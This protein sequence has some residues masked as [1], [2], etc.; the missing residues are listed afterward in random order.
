MCGRYKLSVTGEQLWEFFDLHGDPPQLPLRFNIAPSQPVAVI[1][2]PQRLEWLRWGL[3][4]PRAKSGG[5]NVR[6]ESLGAPIYREAIRT[7][8]CL[9]IAD[10]FYEWKAEGQKRSP[11]LLARTDRRP[12]AFAGIWQRAALLD[13]TEVDACAILTTEASGLAATVHNRMPI[14]LSAAARAPWL[15]LGARFRDLLTSDTASLELFPVGLAV[16][17]AANDDPRCAEPIA[18]AVLA[19]S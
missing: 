8:R 6:S 17:S 12:F 13:G 2:V 5:F 4:I 1:R 18:P 7:Q 11:F 16:N 19:S 14:I 10:G 3:K 15:D 9:I